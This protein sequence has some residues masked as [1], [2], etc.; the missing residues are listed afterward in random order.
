MQ[1]GE[2]TTRRRWCLGAKR[3]SE[4]PTSQQVKIY[5]GRRVT[6]KQ[7][8]KPG[9]PSISVNYAPIMTMTETPAHGWQARMWQ[10]SLGAASGTDLPRKTPEQKYYPY[11]TLTVHL[12]TSDPTSHDRFPSLAA[13]A[14]EPSF[15]SHL[16]AIISSDKCSL[17]FK[18]FYRVPVIAHPEVSRPFATGASRDPRAHKGKIRP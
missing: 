17:S 18:K 16:M 14:L 9:A 1:C 15:H 2:Y 3:C 4:L 8:G 5:E 7:D 10:K 12:P 11:S 13:V 6:L